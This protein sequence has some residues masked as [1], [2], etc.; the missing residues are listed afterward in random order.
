MSSF[1]VYS[2]HCYNIR[3]HLSTKYTDENFEQLKEEA[4]VQTPLS[5]WEYDLGMGG[6]VT[7]ST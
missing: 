4:A 7:V 6:I 3:I 2:C 1:I 5:G